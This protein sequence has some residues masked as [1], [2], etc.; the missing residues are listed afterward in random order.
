MDFLKILSRNEEELKEYLLHNGKSPKPH[1]P[2]YFLKK[3]AL[4]N[5][6][7]ETVNGT[8]NEAD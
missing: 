2:F 3:E 8:V 4:E 6:R 1:A 5:G 7:N